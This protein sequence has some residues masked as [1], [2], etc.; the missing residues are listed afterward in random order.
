MS[1]FSGAFIFSHP[2]FMNLL[3]CPDLSLIYREFVN[4]NIYFKSSFPIGRD[5]VRIP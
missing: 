2:L 3:V 5:C 1:N 4:Y